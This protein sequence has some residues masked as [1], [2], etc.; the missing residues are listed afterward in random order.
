M[1]RIDGY[2]VTTEKNKIGVKRL[3]FARNGD[4]R[5]TIQIR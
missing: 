1:R 3:A 5:S 2:G 4:K